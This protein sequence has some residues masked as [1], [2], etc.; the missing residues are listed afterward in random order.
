METIVGIF[1]GRDRAEEAV[2][3]LL[4]RQVPKE[5]IV[6]LTRSQSEAEN[7]GK[8]LGAYAGGFVGGA[9]GLSAGVAAATLLAIPGLGLS[10]GRRTGPS[11]WI[12]QAGS[13]WLTARHLFAT[14]FD[15][16]VSKG[17]RGS[18]SMCRG[19]IS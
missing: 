11:S 8:E 12:S 9:A 5:S 15:N 13:H 7:L 17:K 18:C 1:A 3:E 14:S 2:K 10:R 4:Q 6:Y 19:S 16:S